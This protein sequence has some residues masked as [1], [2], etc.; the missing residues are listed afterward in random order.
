MGEG[1][2]VRGDAPLKLVTNLAQGADPGLNPVFSPP[3][4]SGLSDAD[5][6]QDGSHGHSSGLRSLF[7]LDHFGGH[8][9]HERHNVQKCTVRQCG[10]ARS[11]ER[12][13]VHYP[14]M[15][16]LADEARA[17]MREALNKTGLAPYALAKKA[18]VS[19]TTIT[20]PLNDPEF[21]FTPKPATLLKI[22]QA[23]GMDL[24]GSLRVPTRSGPVQAGQLPLIGPV[25]AGAWLALDETAQDEPQMIDATMDRRYPHAKQWLRTVNGDSMNL[26][27]IYDGDLAHIVDWT[28][29]GV[30]LTTGM[31][32]EVSRYRAGGGLREVTLKEAEVRPGATALWP[33][34]SNP[35][36]QD[37]I[38]MNDGDED[39]DIEVRITGL[40]LNAIR[41]F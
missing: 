39:S 9:L 41:R 6:G 1:V 5:F 25:Q 17:F 18:G 8:V 27:N 40:L 26:R 35:R 4:P 15:V 19:P 14:A 20:R 21:S 22:A 33:R 38:R 32:V 34:S 28:D 10:N 2:V 31:I 36:F 7:N 30:Q 37:P 24:P 13:Y 3:P 29:A 11:D 23:A 12:A 16:D